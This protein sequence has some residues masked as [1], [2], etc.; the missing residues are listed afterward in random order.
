VKGS[1]GLDRSADGGPTY[2]KV[3]AVTDKFELPGD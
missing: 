1:T 2:K 3:A